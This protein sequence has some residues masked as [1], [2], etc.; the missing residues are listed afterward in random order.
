MPATNGL[1]HLNI[2]LDSSSC[3]EVLVKAAQEG[4]LEAFALLYERYLPVVYRRVLCSVAQADVEDITQDIFIAV[5][6][7]L[8]SFRGEAHFSTWLWTI[9]SRQIADYYRRNRSSQAPLEMDSTDNEHADFLSL[10]SD[11]ADKIDDLVMLRNAMCRLTPHHR[12]ILLMRFADGLKF[13][14]IAARQGQSLEATK[15]MFRR[16]LSALHRLLE[17]ETYA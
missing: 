16:A 12:E 9:T 2:Q 7:S 17:P 4:A 10:P 5:V 14:E 6:R 1:R 15:S 8:K 3:D 11:D 13:Q